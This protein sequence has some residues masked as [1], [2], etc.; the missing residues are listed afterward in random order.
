[1]C[2]GHFFTKKSTAQIFLRKIKRI[3][4]K[5]FSICLL[6]TKSFYIKQD[7]LNN[8]IEKCK[9]NNS[10]FLSLT[11]SKN[12]PVFF[13]IDN[14]ELKIE[15]FYVRNQLRGTAVALYQ[16]TDGENMR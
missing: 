9:E 3:A 11:L 2:Y 8:I 14:T 16:T 15:T 4:H 12:W 13:A 10:V 1:M 6:N 5:D 7:I